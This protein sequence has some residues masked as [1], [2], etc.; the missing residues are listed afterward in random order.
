MS[1]SPDAITEKIH[2][3]LRP[4]LR[5]LP[6]DQPIPADENLGKLGLDSMAA[7]NLLF[8]LEQALDVKIPDELL[9]AETFETAA[10]LEKTI[11]SLAD[12]SQQP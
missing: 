5:F 2:A 3:T 4:H 12:S 10:T 8:D 11:R 9:T 1:A 7:I 6:K